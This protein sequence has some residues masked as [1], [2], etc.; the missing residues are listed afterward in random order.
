LQESSKELQQRLDYN[1]ESSM[2]TEE[3]LEAKVKSLTHEIQSFKTNLDNSEVN[4]KEAEDNLTLKAEE[5]RD[6]NDKV[7][8][9]QILLEKMQSNEAKAKELKDL[10]DLKVLELRDANEE[11]E[12]FKRIADERGNSKMDLEKELQ[13]YKEQVSSRQA[14]HDQMVT[15][16]KELQEMNSSLE[17]EKSEFQQENTA[18]KEQIIEK[19]QSIVDIPTRSFRNRVLNM[20]RNSKIRLRRKIS[21]WIKLKVTL[22]LRKR[23]L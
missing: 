17:K 11:L 22:S 20:K 12:E 3:E 2:K 15:Y 7:E 4:L 13:S 1:L 18:L 6:A 5:L 10:L 16:Q 14:L 8:D 9:L 23:N 21:F 19:D